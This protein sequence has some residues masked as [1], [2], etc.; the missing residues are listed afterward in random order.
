MGKTVYKHDKPLRELQY[1]QVVD[2]A[3]LIAFA[4]MNG[5]RLRFGDAYRDDRV[6]GKYGSKKS[7]SSAYSNH[8]L[9]IANDML[10]DTWD[11]EE[12]EWVWETSS[13]AYAE[14]AHEWEGYRPE[15]VCGIHWGDGNHFSRWYNG[16]W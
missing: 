16:R 4:N 7:Y 10:L 8:K 5:Y 15:N 12:K 2:I 14:L 3:R 9:R 1:E 11:P 13:T 6:H